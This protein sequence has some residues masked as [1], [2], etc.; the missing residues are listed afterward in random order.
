MT[1]ATRADRSRATAS[2]PRQRS[3]AP[4]H[5]AALPRCR[6]PTSADGPLAELWLYGVVG[7]YWFGFNDK[8]VADQLRG[9]NVDHI[10][11]RL[12]SPGGDSIQGIAIGNLFRNHKANGHRR[13]RRPGRLRGLDHRDRRRRGRD[14]AGLPDDDPRPVVLHD[15]QRQGAAAG[16]RLPGQAGRTWPASTPCAAGGT[17][18]VARRHDRRARRHLVHR[19]RGRGGEA[20]RPGRHRHRRVGTAPSRPVENLDDEGDDVAA[21]AAWDLDVLISPAARAWRGAPAPPSPRP[22]PRAGQPNRKELLSWTSTTRRSRPCAS[23]SVSPR[24]RTPTP[25]WRP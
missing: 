22:R 7:G 5:R 10:T 8:T 15:G 9:L 14:V 17:P 11:V 24:T 4:A 21:R 20:R 1:R 6:L 3:P 2:G 18:R 25:S 13:R 12:N 23:R 19:R 16:R